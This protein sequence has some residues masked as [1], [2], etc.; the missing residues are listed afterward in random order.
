[1]IIIFGAAIGAAIL[2]FA[3]GITAKPSAAR[4]NLFAD[5]PVP[6]APES[7][8][9]GIMRSLGQS[10]LRFIPKPLIEGLR[11]NLVMAGHPRGMDMGRLVGLKVLLAALLGGFFFVAGQPVWGLG[12]AVGGFLI[13]DYWMASEKDKRQALMRDAAADTIDQLTIV[14]EAG[15]GFDP[16]LLRVATTN[17]GPL[18]VELRRTVEDMRAGMPRD[19]A[20]R[21][22]ADRTRIPEIR[23]LVT[24]LAQAQRYGTPLADTL[25]V[26]A[27]ELRDK[28]T[29][30]VEE[31]AAKLTTKMI[32]PIVFCFMPVFFI[33][34]LVPALSALVETFAN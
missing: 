4:A 25:R 14:V 17:E 34:V 10:V 31:K 26:Q 19:L 8:L 13:P 32:F 23:R 11:N 24:A 18:A 7:R 3:W 2:S 28:R 1:M 20:L 9:V 16:A 21:G 5:L 12:L 6:S 29:Q 22:L 15:L 33:I 27:H 30:R